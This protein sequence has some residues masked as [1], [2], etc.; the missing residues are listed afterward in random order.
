MNLLGVYEFL[1]NHDMMVKGGYYACRD[2]AITQDLCA[3]ALFLIGGFNS[4]Q[5]NKVF[6]FI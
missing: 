1:P 4:D 2:E 6:L 3:V 5:L